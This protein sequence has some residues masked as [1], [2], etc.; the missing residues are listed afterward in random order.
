MPT[1]FM[2]LFKDN[3][4]DEKPAVKKEDPNKFF[5]YVPIKLGKK[6]VVFKSSKYVEPSIQTGTQ[7]VY[8]GRYK[9]PKTKKTYVGSII[10]NTKTTSSSFTYVLNNKA[11]T[12]NE[13][14]FEILCSKD[15]TNYFW[16]SANTG[17]ALD[18]NTL[19]LAG[20]ETNQYY[21]VALNKGELQPGVAT[22]EKDLIK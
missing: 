19:E 18:E 6:I 5:Y 22:V 17:D 10:S 14:D 21:V 1:K 3:K 11:V 4:T 16:E 2:M 7:N 13:G 9:D 12:V 8:F 15:L 20:N